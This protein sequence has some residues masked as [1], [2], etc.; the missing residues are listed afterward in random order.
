MKKALVL[1]IVGCVTLVGW[2]SPEVGDFVMY[3]FKRTLPNG[4]VLNGNYRNEIITVTDT[5]VISKVTITSPEIGTIEQTELFLRESI[6]SKT[7]IAHILTHC[8]ARG[9][10]PSQIVV[11]GGSFTT[12]QFSVDNGIIWIGMV[13][14]GYVK[15]A[16][17]G[18][19]GSF[20]FEV[21]NYRF[22][23]R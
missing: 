15:G 2:A 20:K 3:T 11:E 13:P 14:F 16:L 7:Q 5:E 12:C 17:F 23:N 8:E 10:I 1:I 22:G 4:T 19:D 21:S 18:D 9:G 6:M